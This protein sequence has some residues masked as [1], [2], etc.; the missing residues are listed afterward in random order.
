MFRP[1]LHSG[2]GSL[3]EV[4]GRK[5]NARRKFPATERA[6]GINSSE[7]SRNFHVVA[8]SRRF[9]T[10]SSTFLLFL[11]LHPH[12]L[13]RFHP[14]AQRKCTCNTYMTREGLI[15]DVTRALIPRLSAEPVVIPCR[16]HRV[17]RVPGHRFRQCQCQCQCRQRP[18]SLDEFA[19]RIL[20]CRSFTQ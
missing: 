13:P 18:L 6:N 2:S 10:S 8:R 17:S 5:F 14:P 9:S 16:L 19:V 11:S 1:V 15:A 3:S 12:L 7:A 4:R 20:S